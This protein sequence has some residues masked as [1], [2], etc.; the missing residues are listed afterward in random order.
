MSQS[1]ERFAEV[2]EA[3]CRKPGVTFG[4]PGSKLFGHVALKVND[5]IFAMVSSSS[6]HFVV[7]LPKARIDALETGDT[8]RRFEASRGR[9]TKEWFEVHSESGEEWLQLAHEAL[10]FVGSLR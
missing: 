8:G 5:K 2:V 1:A 6:G 3:L 10:A 9:P 4:K 7:K